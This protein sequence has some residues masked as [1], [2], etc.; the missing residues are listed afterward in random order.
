MLA[1]SGGDEGADGGGAGVVYFFDG[2][3]GYYCAGYEGGVG[4][5]VEEDVE[6]GWRG[7][8][9]GLPFFFF[10]GDEGLEEGRG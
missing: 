10:Y 5:A 2:G 4:G 8:V 6:A 9:K 1:G 3:V 7:L